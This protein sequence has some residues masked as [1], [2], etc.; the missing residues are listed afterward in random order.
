MAAPVIWSQDALDDLEAIASYIGRDSPYHAQQVVEAILEVAD[1]I[2]AQPRMGR[3]VP[4]L[5]DPNVRERFVYSYRVI[6]EIG[7]SPIAIL[8]VI[9]GRRLLESIE[10][11]FS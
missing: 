4:E 5:K 8:A 11:R 10:D 1:S 9:H 7:E 6:Y 2:P 3:E